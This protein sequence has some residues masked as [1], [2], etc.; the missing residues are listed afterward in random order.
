M[1]P[2]SVIPWMRRWAIYDLEILH[3]SLYQMAS[4]PIIATAVIAGDAQVHED[5]RV[6][7]VYDQIA[8]HFS[9]TRYNVRSRRRRPPIAS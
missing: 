5:T 6:H 1:L 8:S 3:L 2:G 4:R 7:R 9:S